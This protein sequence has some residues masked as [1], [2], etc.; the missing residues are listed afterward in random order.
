MKKLI[1]VMLVLLCL[2]S[3][4]AEADPLSGAILFTKTVVW[5][6]FFSAIFVDQNYCY[7]TKDDP[8]PGYDFG[9]SDY[10]YTKKIDCKK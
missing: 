10:R 8:L 7:A 3:V 6:G 5:A 2:G 9:Y 1:T 4:S